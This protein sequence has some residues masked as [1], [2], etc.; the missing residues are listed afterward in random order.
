MRLCKFIEENRGRSAFNG[1]TTEDI[2]NEIQKPL[3]STKKVSY[4]DYL[5]EKNPQSAKIKKA[6]VFI[7]H[8]WQY[9][10]LDVVDAINQQFQDESDVSISKQ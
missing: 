8:A 7:S 2:N 10:F 1:K 4:C 3:T 6:N 5:K 9:K